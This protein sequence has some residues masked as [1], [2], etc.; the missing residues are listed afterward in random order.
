MF[1]GQEANSE[2]E[3]SMAMEDI[4]IDKGNAK[5]KENQINKDHLESD[6]IL[7]KKIEDGLK[8][9]M[10]DFRKNVNIGAE[11]ETV[12][13]GYYQECFPIFEE[14]EFQE[15]IKDTQGG[16]KGKDG[17]EGKKGG[18]KTSDARK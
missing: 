2:D 14:N 12:E 18:N 16:G 15:S 5:S 10:I 1:D 3:D 11:L 9:E 17:Q 13:D 8:N 6:L 7:E 4:K